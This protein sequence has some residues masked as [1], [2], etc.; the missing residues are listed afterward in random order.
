MNR[1]AVKEARGQCLLSD[2]VEDGALLT[3]EPQMVFELARILQ[4]IDL[5][6]AVRSQRDPDA[7]AHHLVSDDHA[8]AKIAFGRGA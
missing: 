5:R 6:L 3:L 8:V 7:L 4:W 1:G 2:L